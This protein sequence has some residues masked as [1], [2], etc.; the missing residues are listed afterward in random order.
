LWSS[1]TDVAPDAAHWGAVAD[2][3]GVA[4]GAAST[5]LAAAMI[6][7]RPLR[8][9]GLL[10]ALALPLPAFCPPNVSGANGTDNLLN[11]DY[12]GNLI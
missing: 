4:I 12:R 3:A 6:E 11:H 5:E 7:N 10:E 1:E 9:F 2:C 8:M